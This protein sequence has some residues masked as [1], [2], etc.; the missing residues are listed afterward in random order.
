[1]IA[2]I[3]TT[4]TAD[5]KKPR[6]SQTVPNPAGAFI[7]CRKKETA[8]IQARLKTNSLISLPYGFDPDKLYAVILAMQVF[9]VLVRHYNT[10]ETEP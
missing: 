4:V 1:M 5:L 2:N 8:N 3:R 10:L 9:K 7:M 6:K